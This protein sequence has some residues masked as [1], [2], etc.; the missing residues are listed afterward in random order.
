MRVFSALAVCG[1]CVWTGLA[2]RRDLAR[3]ARV[4]AQIR[5]LL[6]ELRTRA[7]IG[8]P[9]LSLVQSLS[10]EKE[11]RTLSFLSDCCSYCR[12]DEDFPA[13][14]AHAARDFLQS[15]C[16]DGEIA[17]FLPQIGRLLTVGNGERLASML[18][19]YE[20]VCAR[21]LAAARQKLATGGK[22]CVQ[23]GVGA[24]VLLGILI[25]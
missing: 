22:L 6:T 2:I 15:G 16:V 10:E 11:L 5:L 12:A 23:I 20:D 13:A 18:G 14:W 21:R 19:A 25:L 24:G 7:V 17:S 8:E 9:I 4:C 3:R 1:G